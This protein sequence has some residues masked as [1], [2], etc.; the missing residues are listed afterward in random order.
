[1][2]CIIPITKGSREKLLGT[3]YALPYL[4]HRLFA[5]YITIF[6]LSHT[7]SGAGKVNLVLLRNRF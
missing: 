1:M 3:T 7:N 2:I 6:K 5:V 4:A